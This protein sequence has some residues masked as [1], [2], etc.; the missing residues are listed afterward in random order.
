M[1]D[2]PNRPNDASG[3]IGAAAEGVLFDGVVAQRQAVWIT[4]QPQGLLMT[5][6]DAGEEAAFWSWAEVRCAPHQRPSDRPLRL[7][8]AADT[9]RPGAGD[10]RLTLPAGPDGEPL[11]RQILASAPNLAAPPPFVAQL[12]RRIGVTAA[13]AVAALALILYGLIPLLASQFA[14]LVPPASEE[15]LGDS[16][17]DQVLATDLFGAAPGPR[18]CSAPRGLAALEKMQD[19]LVAVADP[20]V[21]IVALVANFPSANALALPGG[22]IIL[23]RGLIEQADTPEEVAGVFAHEIGHVRARDPTKAALRAGASFGLLSMVLGD[24]AGG[25]VIAGV[26]SSLLEA[27][28]SRGV[29]AA[30]DAAALEI[31]RAAEVPH[32]PMASFFDRLIAEYGEDGGA[33]SS[34]PSSRAR[35]ERIRTSGPPPSPRAPPIL[36]DSEWR[37]LQAICAD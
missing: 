30:A 6:R 25:V 5:R 24:A 11:A 19:R 22:Y 34:H 23:F 2:A 14:Q 28:Y 13:A 15:A 32:A 35:A 9:L 31:L 17:V 36:T 33:L 27:R 4:A 21:E 3:R 37:A 18:V 26:A 1:T 12:R 7:A 10:A 20:H 29:E 16:I 8:L